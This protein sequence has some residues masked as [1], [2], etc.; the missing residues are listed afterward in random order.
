M[1]T[2][3]K[4]VPHSSTDEVNIVNTAPTLNKYRSK[5]SLLFDHNLPGNSCLGAI[6]QK[7]LRECSWL[8]K[9]NALEQS[10]AAFGKFCNTLVDDTSLIHWKA[11]SSTLSKPQGCTNI[12]A[13]ANNIG[14]FCASRFCV[15]NNFINVSLSC[16]C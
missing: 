9:E 13:H 10:K 4:L 14:S 15:K 1:A 7:L 3:F 11:P 16:W 2:V 8:L 5:G 12:Q 6:E